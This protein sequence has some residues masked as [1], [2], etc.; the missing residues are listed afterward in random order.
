MLISFQKLRITYCAL[1]IVLVFLALIFAVQQSFAQNRTTQEQ[2]NQ[3]QERLIEL[4][5]ELDQIQGEINKHAEESAS[6]E[7]DINII[8]N[9]IRKIR[10]E[11][12]RNQLII[13]ETSFE[14]QI[15]TETIEGLN[16]RYEN[17]E[18]L[19]AKL[20]LSIYKLD[21]TSSL[22]IFLTTQSLSEFFNDV[23]NI[24][25]LQ[26][27]MAS[28]LDEIRLTKAD[29]EKEIAQLDI[30]LDN[31]AVLYQENITQ[32]NILDQK[33]ENQE[34]LLFESR[35]KEYRFREAAQQTQRSIQQ[36]RDQIFR[37]E[38]M[39][40]RL[41]FGEAYKYA[42]QAEQLTGVRA[43]LTLSVLK[44][45]S[46][47][48][49]NVGQCLLVDTKTGMGRRVN[50]GFLPRVMAPPSRRNDIQ[51]FLQLTQELGKDPFST[52]VSCWMVSMGCTN[53]NATT[54]SRATVDSD[55]T[56]HCPQNTPHLFGFGGAIG[57]A[58]FLPTTW[59]GYKDRVSALL[60]RTADPWHIL[61]AFVASAVKLGDGGAR[62]Q[63]YN[64]ELCAVRTYFSGNC[65][66]HSSIGYGNQ[67]MRRAAEYQR[68]ID[69]L[70]GG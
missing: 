56:A 30:K 59:M 18:K 13:N 4:Q 45:E 15:N 7:R 65:T 21:D 48:G 24:K 46:N 35:T 6:Y 9:E 36:I 44:Q 37:L 38:G 12:Q 17:N 10:I 60:G 23:N 41:T 47:W 70:E 11:M 31:Q 62:T 1:L 32:Q 50:G 22:E 28:A 27:G 49:A 66:D 67:V 20:L 34:Q 3:L 26:E 42:K 40:R 52:P 54:F 69:I 53:S 58:Q 64:A 5:K 68:D 25:N 63:I 8:R 55:G 19:L 51:T 2:K 14:I 29:L 43:A 61:D 16:K 39:D 57:P 33:V